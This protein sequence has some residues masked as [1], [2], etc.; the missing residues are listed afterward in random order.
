MTTLAAA[1]RAALCD[2]LLELGPDAPTLCEGWDAA[3]LAAHLWTRERDPLSLAGV[4]APPLKGVAERR[5][6]RALER[7]GFEGLVEDLRTPPALSPFAVP[8]VD[9]AANAVEYLV[10]REDLRRGADPA[11]TP[12]LRRTPGEEDEL[13]SR[14]AAMAPMLMRRS[15]V[16]VI[17]ERA[18]APEGS[19]RQRIAGPRSGPAVVVRGLPSELVLFAFGRRSAA[20][21][22]V[23]GGVDAVAA[24]LDADYGL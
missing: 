18:D 16:G 17:A 24:F 14:L 6:A 8:A 10:H 1:E 9:A 5:M 2:L 22:E 12:P 13:W 19:A 20:E 7:R 4:V 15:P 21:V 11:G 23:T 3:D